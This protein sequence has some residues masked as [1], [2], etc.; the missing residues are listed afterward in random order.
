MKY[1]SC[2]HIVTEVYS[3]HKE[4]KKWKKLRYDYEIH[5]I[6]RLVESKQTK[7]LKDITLTQ[8]EHLAQQINTAAWD[9]MVICEIEIYPASTLSRQT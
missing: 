9:K 8:F 3:W 7:Y 1:S 4:K 5:K 6:V 2:F